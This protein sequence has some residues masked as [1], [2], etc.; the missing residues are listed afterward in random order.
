MLK[1][2]LEYYK[3]FEEKW[4]GFVNIIVKYENAILPTCPHCGSWHTAQVSAG[5]VSA[6][7]TLLRATTRFMIDPQHRGRLFC[8]DCKQFFTPEDYEGPIW[9]HELINLSEGEE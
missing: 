1:G 7:F 8:N 5:F 9:W 3:R 2:S 4:P 6:S